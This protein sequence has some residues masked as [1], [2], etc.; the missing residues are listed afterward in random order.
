MN[1]L[2]IDKKKQVILALVEG[3]SIRSIERMTGVNRNTIMTQMKRVGAGC[4]KLLDE[5]MKNLDCEALQVDEIWTFVQKKQKSLSAQ[6]KELRDDIGDQYVFVALDAKTKIIPSF[7]VGKRNGDTT[8]KFITDLK[9]RLNGIRPQLTTD[10]YRPYVDAIEFVFGCNVDYAQL[11]KLYEGKSLDDHK[12]SPPKVKGT[13]KKRI[14]G[15][16]DRKKI[17]T[18]YIERQNLTMRMQMRRFTRST[19]AFSKKL[20]NLK[21]A[22]YLHFAFYNFVRVHRTLRVTPAMEAGITDR[23]W[24]VEDLFDYGC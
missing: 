4:K 5:K 3:N 12:Y 17:S 20:E 10:G 22:L 2:P 18:S 7:L 19:N 16:S 6:E 23:L 15:K 21:A 1:C 9:S 11:I 13:Q 14:M 24:E 8:F